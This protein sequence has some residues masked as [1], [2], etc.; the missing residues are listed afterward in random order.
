MITTDGASKSPESPTAKPNHQPWTFERQPSQGSTRSSDTIGSLVSLGR[1]PSARK[2]GTARSG[3]I[4]ETHVDSGGVRKVVLE[5]HG[6]SDDERQGSSGKSSPKSGPT[7]A[8]PD[9]S[10]DD[11]DEQQEFGGEATKKKRRRVRRKKNSGNSN[12]G[13]E[14]GSTGQ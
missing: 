11:H 12:N 2:K 6:N 14:E 13:G 7:N 5:T 10:Q 8:G 3:S 9:S 1:T 4:T